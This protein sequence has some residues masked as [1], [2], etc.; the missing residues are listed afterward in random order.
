MKDKKDSNSDSSS[1]SEE[2][3]KKGNSDFDRVTHLASRL[4]PPSKV[5]KKKYFIMISSV[6]GSL[7]RKKKKKKD[8]SSSNSSS[9]EE[10]H[11]KPREKYAD[12][13][14]KY[15]TFDMVKKS[16]DFDAT[17]LPRVQ[18]EM[19]E[20]EYRNTIRPLPSAKMT[21]EDKKLNAKIFPISSTSISLKD[22]KH[23][24]YSI[25]ITN[26]RKIC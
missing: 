22:V 1:D 2:E 10:D 24:V 11:K 4:P 17:T 12:V 6:H 21:G 5:E 3:K 16:S 14:T 23:C 15:Q 18:Q 8:N 25:K 26:C 20:S 9:E 7:I 19:R 13:T